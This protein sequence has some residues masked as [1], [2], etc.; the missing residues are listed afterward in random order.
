[1]VEGIL[2]EQV[3]DSRQ[4]GTQF[5][6]KLLLSLNEQYFF[7]KKLQFFE[8]FTNVFNFKILKYG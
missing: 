2:F 3:E 8:Y 1:M 5:L 6:Q 4:H 7:R